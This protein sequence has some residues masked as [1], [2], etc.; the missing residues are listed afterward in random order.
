MTKTQIQKK[1]KALFPGPAEAAAALGVTPRAVGYWLAGERSMTRTAQILL[2][3]IERER[4][5]SSK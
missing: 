3:Y 1:L 4:M 5:P 2:G